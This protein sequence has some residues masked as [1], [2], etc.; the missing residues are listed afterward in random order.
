MF[1]FSDPTLFFK[2]HSDISEF[3][4]KHISVYDKNRHFIDLICNNP[5]YNIQNMVFK[6]YNGD[7]LNAYMDVE[8]VYQKYKTEYFYRVSITKTMLYEKNP[9]NSQKL[10][11]DSIFN[12]SNSN[13][14]SIDEELTKE[15]KVDR[16]WFWDTFSFSNISK[17]KFIK[18]M[19]EFIKKAEHSY[20]KLYEAKLF[21]Q[22]DIINKT[23]KDLAN[24]AY[25]LKFSDF[26]NILI[27]IQISCNDEEINEYFNK[28]KDFI[29]KLNEITKKEML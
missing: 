24:Y 25:K 4:V 10:N 1:G 21:N 12:F 11:S 13:A 20:E 2:T 7:I 28:Y 17:D 3:F 23:V 16:I 27:N 18:L 29:K 8:I 26:L 9:T 19:H 14:Q 15:Y 6:L 5:E 22:M